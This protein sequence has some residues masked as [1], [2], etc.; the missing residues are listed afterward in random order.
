MSVSDWILTGRPALVVIHMQNAIVK[1]PSPLEVLGHPRATAEDEVIPHIARLLA[2]FRERGLP[3]VFTA[4]VH[5]EAP[6]LPAYGGFWGAVRDMTV[7]QAGTRDVEIVDELAPRDGEPVVHNWPFDVFRRTGLEELLRGQGV[8]TIV[9][10]GVST[11]MAVI[12][13]AY[14]A[15]DRGFNLILPSDCI[16][17][18]NRQLHEA[19]MTGIMPVIGLVTSSEDVA[20]RL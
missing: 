13:A 14:Q 11:G 6:E 17:D 15:A 8:E 20:A 18:G 7:N 19:I 10:V 9:L 2:V 3:V 16:T 5:P 4:A 1:A 12:I